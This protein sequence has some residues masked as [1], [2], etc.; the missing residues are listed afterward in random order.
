ML[1]H[2]K[3]RKLMKLF[4][5]VNF[6]I[7]RSVSDLSL[8]KVARTLNLLQKEAPSTLFVHTIFP[9]VTRAKMSLASQSDMILS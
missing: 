4:T 2:I 1:F 6:E 7:I 8:Q 3:I 9:L 5:L